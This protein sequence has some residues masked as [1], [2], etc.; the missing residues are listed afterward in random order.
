MYAFPS[1]S[2]AHGLTLLR[3][4]ESVYSWSKPTLIHSGRPSENNLSELYKLNFGT[5]AIALTLALPDAEDPVLPRPLD[6]DLDLEDGEPLGGLE[7]LLDLTLVQV[8]PE[9]AG[10]ILVAAWN[11]KEKKCNTTVTQV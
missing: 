10:Q 11:W 3:L 5:N 6:A 2:L 7:D 1:F 4:S 9:A 8:L